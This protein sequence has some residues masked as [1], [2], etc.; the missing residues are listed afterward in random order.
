M[1]LVSILFVILSS[2]IILSSIVKRDSAFLYLLLIAFSQIVLSFEI[3]SLFKFISVNGILICNFVFFIIALLFFVL[4]K[5]KFYVPKIELKK[6]LFAIKQDKALIFLSFCFVLFLIFQLIRIIFFPITFG[7]ALVYYFTRCTTW[8]QNGSISHFVTSDTR[9]LIMPVNMDFLY[10]WVLLFN[11]NEKGLGIFSFISYI[12]GIYVI[13]ELLRELKFSIKRCLW[14]IFVFSS[15]ALVILEMVTPCSDLF[16]GVL[17]LS[18]IYL[19]LKYIKYEDKTAL[20]F[21]TLSYSLAAG[22]KTTAIIA[23]PSLFLILLAIS[24]IY[25]KNWKN[26]IK[27]GFLFILNFIIFSSYNYILNFIQFQNPISNQ[28]QLLLNQFQGGIKG[29]I[30]NVVKYAFTIFDMSGVPKFINLNGLIEYW[31]SLVLKLFGTT[32]KNGTSAYFP[33]YFVFDNTMTLVSSALGVMGLFVYL[34]SLIYSIKRGIKKRKSKISLIIAVLG[35]S[36]I[37]NIL[38]FSKVMIFTGYNMRYIFT[39]VVISVPIIVYSYKRNKLYKIFLCLIMFVY[40]IGYAHH[41]PVSYILNCIKIKGLIQT[42]IKSEE[43]N[44]YEYLIKK[45][46]VKIAIM[47]DQSK[48]LKYHIEKLKLIGI[49]IEKIL[50]EN[51][52]TYDLS[53]YDYIITNKAIVDATITLNFKER[54]KY[55]A[56]YVSECTYIDKRN[57]EIYDIGQERQIAFVECKVPF[58]YLKRK[59]FVIDTNYKGEEYTIMAALKNI[60]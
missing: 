48:F 32:I 24:Y 44:M 14:S 11:K 34:P 6:I 58:E 49:K 3:L 30:A 26:V 35:C 45:K 52:E 50:A 1:L 55:K 36:V 46:P 42:Y 31:Q 37:F 7:D 38:L 54:M 21:S 19:Y 51:I 56:L 2:Y 10:T 53:E 4:T 5:K 12:C 43:D 22:T 16:I 39:F 13:Y 18:S 9:E 47:T 23:M 20:Y 27:F 15:F 29:Y 25:K 33:Y 59:N 40:L 60:R 8:I 28:Q 57:N 17:I 41:K